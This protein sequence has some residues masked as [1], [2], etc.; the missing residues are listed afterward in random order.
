[1]AIIQSN[2]YAPAAQPELRG[3]EVASR[4]APLQGGQ[5]Q[6]ERVVLASAAQ[7][8]ADAAEE[9]TFVFSERAELSLA[10]RKLSDSHARI[11]EIEALVGGLPRQGAGAGAPAEDQG[12]GE[13]P[14]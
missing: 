14:R 11:S 2:P 13:S 12:D 6:G 4:Q 10:K 1:M 3:A 7:S 9:L 5:F 8:L